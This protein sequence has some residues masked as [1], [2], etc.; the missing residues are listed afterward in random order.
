MLEQG[1]EGTQK[2]HYAMFKQ[3]KTTSRYRIDAPLMFSDDSKHLG[4][5]ITVAMEIWRNSK[6]HST[7]HE[8]SSNVIKKSQ[9]ATRKATDPEK[10]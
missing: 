6:G 8:L 1:E 10:N 9:T 4:R 2:T 3:E 5:E 7:C